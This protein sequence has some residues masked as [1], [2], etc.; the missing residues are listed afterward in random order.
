VF[1]GHRIGLEVGKPIYQDL[2]GPQ[3]ETDLVW[4]LGYQFMMM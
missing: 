4:S 2:N 1:G 3:M